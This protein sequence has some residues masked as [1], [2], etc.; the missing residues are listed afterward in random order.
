MRKETF[1]V[2][3]PEE[4]LTDLRERL[5]RIRWPNDFN[6]ADWAYGTNKAYLMEL[7][8]YW[9]NGYDWRKTESEINSFSK[10]SKL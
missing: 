5:S 3:V 10:F 6:N 9:L 2:A 1:N 7:V 8:D 4:T